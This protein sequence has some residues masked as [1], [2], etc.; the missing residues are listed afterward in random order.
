MDRRSIRRVAD[1]GSVL[2]PSGTIFARPGA[3]VPGREYIITSAFLATAASGNTYPIVMK[4]TGDTWAAP[5]TVIFHKRANYSATGTLQ[6]SIFSG[7]TTTGTKVRPKLVG[8][9]LN[10]LATGVC[11]NILVTVY[12]FYNATGAATTFTWRSSLFGPA[13]LAVTPGAATNRP[14]MIRMMVVYTGSQT[15]ANQIESLVN[16][17]LSLAFSTGVST[18]AASGTQTFDVSVQ[19]SGV[20]SSYGVREVTVEVIP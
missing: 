5:R 19:P 20:G 15:Y 16:T 8:G 1:R 12:G 13:T 17:S 4:D 11:R 10:G 14:G 6:R 3:G 9:I 7:A 18:V 2:I